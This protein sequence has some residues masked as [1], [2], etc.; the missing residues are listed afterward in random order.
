MT[1][2]E[3]RELLKDRK[4]S[5]DL[6]LLDNN[7]KPFEIKNI[8]RVP[9]P[10]KEDVLAFKF[11]NVVKENIVFKGPTEGPTGPSGGPG[12]IGVQTSASAESK[13]VDISGNEDMWKVLTISHPKSANYYLDGSMSITCAMEIKNA[14]CLVRV[15]GKNGESECMEFVSGTTIKETKD[16]EGNVISRELFMDPELL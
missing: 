4:G 2:K 13:I 5:L 8:E 16:K 9:W 14:G 15:I 7:N 12:S 3:L 11:N 10:G 6:I 1:A